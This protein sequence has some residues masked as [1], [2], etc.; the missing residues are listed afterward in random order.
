MKLGIVTQAR[1]ESLRLIEWI[2]FHQKI[3]FE[4]IVI[5]D[6][7]ST[8][9]SIEKIKSIDGVFVKR[10]VDHGRR[11]DTSDPN[12]YSGARD[13]HERQMMS[14]REGMQLLK[15]EDCD[16]VAIIDVDEFIVPQNAN[17]ARDYFSNLP[18]NVERV[19]VA[20]YDMQYPFD[21][22]KPLIPQSLYRWSEKTRVEGTAKGHSPG[23]YQTRGKSIVKLASW[24]GNV[25]GVHD[26]TKSQFISS[27]T[28]LS[29]FPHVLSVLR[30]IGLT[31]YDLGLK[32]FHYRA[33]SIMPIY[34]EYD[35][36]ALQLLNR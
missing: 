16:W 36:T 35:D 4:K 26:V 25:I 9:N 14:F 15:Q 7:A 29:K 31:N 22:Q 3:G 2:S 12:V 17:D 34:D 21:L 28:E 23:L 6:D 24:D 10:T 8:D 20:S 27:G 11:F 13:Y 1:N 18:S 30:S 19:Y 32:I 5:F 33:N